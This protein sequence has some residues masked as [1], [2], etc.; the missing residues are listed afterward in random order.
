VRRTV[1][2]DKQLSAELN[3]VISFTREKPAV[4]I[5]QAI[6]AGR[7]IVT[8][9]FSAPRPEGHFADACPRPKERKELQAATVQSPPK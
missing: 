5:R 3:H 9:R 4:V 1:D 6:R 2:L 7:P 8:N